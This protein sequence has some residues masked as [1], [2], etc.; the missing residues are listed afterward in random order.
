MYSVAYVNPETGQVLVPLDS[1]VPEASPMSGL[2]SMVQS[3]LSPSPSSIVISRESEL[4]TTPVA[5]SYTH[6]R[7]HET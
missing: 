1:S 5:V 7:A 3:K 2:V 6:L 4:I